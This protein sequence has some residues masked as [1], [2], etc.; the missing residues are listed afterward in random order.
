M[1][2]ARAE[3]ALARGEPEVARAAWTECLATPDQGLCHLRLGD[4]AVREGRVEAALAHYARVT[5]IG[6]A[7]TL[8]KLRGCELLGTCLGP[9]DSARAAEV[10]TLTEELA[11]EVRLSSVR[12]ELVAGRDARAMQ[13]LVQGLERDSQLCAGALP[14]CQKLVAVGLASEDAD[15]RIGALSTFLTD[16]VRKGPAEYALNVA[17]AEAARDLGA[18]AFAASILSANT[19]LVP[20]AELGEHLLRIVTLYLVARDPVRAA[21]VLEYAEGKLGG[22]NAGRWVQVRRQLGRR[23]QKPERLAVERRPSLEALSSD[24]ALTTDLARATALRSKA[25]E[26]FPPETAP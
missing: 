22:A 16:K 15:A 12:R 13:W 8:A 7:G 4:L 11:R 2:A 10:T 26:P 3:C 17:A 14:L 20:R 5:T 1:A 19:P 24:V 23:P 6:P 25:A 21:V 18:P 9:L